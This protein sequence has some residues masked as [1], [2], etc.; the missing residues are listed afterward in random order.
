MISRRVV[1]GQLC[2]AALYQVLVLRVRLITSAAVRE[3]EAEEKI[4]HELSY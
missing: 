3:K 2:Q 4:S 1:I